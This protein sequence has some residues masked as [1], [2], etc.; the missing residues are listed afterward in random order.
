MTFVNT[1]GMAFFGPGSEWFW[2]ALQF[3][4]LTIT[5]IAIYRQ[6]QSA[7][8]SRAV[9]QVEG[10]RRQLDGEQMAR[11]QLAILVALR[12]REEIPGAAGRAIGNYFE[13]LGSLGRK[14]HVDIKLLWDL[15]SFPALLWWTVLAPYVQ[16]QRVEL[17]ESMLEEFEWL[18]GAFARMDGRAGRQV[19]VN[20]ASVANWLAAAAGEIEFLQ[21]R[22]RVEQSLRSV[23][24]APSNGL[25]RAQLGAAAAPPTPSL[26]RT[27]ANDLDPQSD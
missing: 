7:R 19:A 21:D 4:A 26:S 27:V 17:G 15:V 14:G 9:E 5:F 12:D 16:R 6:L 23:I 8:S 20:K 2:A 10:Y 1:K 18:V 25:D 11:Y 22:I 24:I 3:T 13:M